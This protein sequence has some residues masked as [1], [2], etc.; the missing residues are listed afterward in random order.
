V[1]N[2]PRT[3]PY[4]YL[5]RGLSPIPLPS[6]F[7]LVFGILVNRTSCSDQTPVAYGNVNS[8][9]FKPT[10]MYPRLHLAWTPTSK[11]IKFPRLFIKVL[12]LG[13]MSSGSPKIASW[14]SV[15]SCLPQKISKTRH[16]TFFFLVHVLP[17]TVWKY[18]A[19]ID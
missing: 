11:L 15:V 16:I 1:E 18:V 13:E 14:H 5:I 10:A 17:K 8:N 3:G 4:V 7:S 9:P 12:E 6:S 2:E 19:D